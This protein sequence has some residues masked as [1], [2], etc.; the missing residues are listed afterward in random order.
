MIIKQVVY[1]VTINKIVASYSNVCRITPL[2]VW[3]ALKC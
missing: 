3:E 2:I 1:S